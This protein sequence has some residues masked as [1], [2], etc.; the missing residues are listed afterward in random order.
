MMI[1]TG[2]RFVP[3]AKEC[4]EGTPLYE[5]HMARYY[6]A[7]RYLKGKRI[8]DIACGTGYGA[9]LLIDCGASE[10][11]GIDISTE[12][13]EFAKKK[14]QHPSLHFLISDA[15]KTSFKENTFDCVVSFET[16]EHLKNYRNFKTEVQRIL[17]PSGT[18]IISSPNRKVYGKDKEIPDNKFHVKEFSKNEFLNLWNEMF[19]SQELFGQCNSVGPSF[20]R[21][22]LKKLS[23]IILFIDY[24]KFR[25]ILVPDRSIDYLL[26]QIGES[27]N[28]YEIFPCNSYHNPLYFISVCTK[29]L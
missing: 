1:F 15:T 26:D 28:K 7:S 27:K 6:F 3:N 29:K 21:K 11:V 22:L 2:E 24:F 12:A 20:A 16:I 4:T 13:I 10:V 14:Y 8:I 25:R 19:K 17:K 23:M 9:K 18:L 5:A